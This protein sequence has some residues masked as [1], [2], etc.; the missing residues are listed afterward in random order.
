MKN[1]QATT[2]AG[3]GTGLTSVGA[4]ITAAGFVISPNSTGQ[5]ACGVEAMTLR[6]ALES[7]ERPAGELL[8]TC[9][10]ILDSERAEKQAAKLNAKMVADG[11]VS[12]WL[13]RVGGKP[14]PEPRRGW[15]ATFIDAIGA[16]VLA[17]QQWR[18]GL[19]TLRQADGGDLLTPSEPDTTTT[20]ARVS[21]RALVA[22]VAAD[23]LG[24]HGDAAAGCPSGAADWWDWY[25]LQSGAGQRAARLTA[26]DILTAWQVQRARAK[27]LAHVEAMRDKLASG[28]GRRAALADKV[29]QA[30]VLMLG[31]LSADDAATAAGFKASEPRQGGGG[32]VSAGDRM[33]AALRRAGLRVTA[34]RGAWAQPVDDFEAVR[35]RGGAVVDLVRQWRPGWQTADG[36]PVTAAAVSPVV[37]V[38]PPVLRGASRR[39]ARRFVVDGVG[40][41]QVAPAVI[42]TD[43]WRNGAVVGVEVEPA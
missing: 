18:A 30:A 33:A 20:A 36:Q 9:Q 29:K 32:R 6:Q 43:I 13:T 34:K 14:L 39:L 42:L 12:G 16:A 41:V 5:R 8:A 1:H 3:T 27:R 35:V 17:V 31:G 2:G 21:W 23:D 7:C 25:C 26:G 38:A 19:R 40:V 22:S 11:R 4:A 24:T 10:A 28:R 37:M 15:S